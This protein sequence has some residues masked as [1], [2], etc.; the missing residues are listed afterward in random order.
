[1]WGVLNVTPDS[2]SDGGR[3]LDP[4]AALQHAR[5]MARAGA[6]VI[7]VGGASSRP[8]GPLYGDGA[9]EIS[10][11]E[12]LRRVVPVVRALVDELELRVSVDTTRPEV[13]RAALQAGARVV[14]DVSCGAS[15]GVLEAV[16]AADAEYVLMHTRGAG[17]VTPDNTAYEDVMVDVRDEL[18]A[19]VERAVAHGVARER[20]WLDPGLGFAKTT[21]QSIVLLSNLRLLVATG[22]RV[23]VGASRKGFI[24]R[25]APRADGSAPEP[26]E[27]DAGTAATVAASVAQGASAVRVH[28]V[29]GM[30]QAML[31]AAALNARGGARTVRGDVAPA[32]DVGGNA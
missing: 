4:A 14:N 31:V 12:E 20:I 17:E 32:Q 9:P 11:D 28:D 27:R 25:I 29:A 23:L 16:A 2:F 3:F 5:G 7:D 24:A 15:E 13:A 10:V 1:V 19:V 22:H 26:D 8:R 6:D 21:E 18:L 30:R